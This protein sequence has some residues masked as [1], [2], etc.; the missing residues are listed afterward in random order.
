MSQRLESGQLIFTGD[1]SPPPP[2]YFLVNA[3]LGFALPVAGHP[4][5]VVLTGTNLANTDYR[6]YLNRFRYFADEPGRTISLRIRVPIGGG[7]V[8]P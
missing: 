1:F 6:D 5:R 3:E 4:W 2:A 7:R 8:A